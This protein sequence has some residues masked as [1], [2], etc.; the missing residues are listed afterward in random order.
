MLNYTK[1]IYKK[2]KEKNKSNYNSKEK[3]QK[4]EIKFWE[5][6]CK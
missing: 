3:N 4:K 5:F 1:E 6:N 2:R